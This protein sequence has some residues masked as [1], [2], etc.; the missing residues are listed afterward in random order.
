MRFKKLRGAYRKYL[1]FIFAS[2]EQVRALTD[3]FER[4]FDKMDATAA[5]ATAGDDAGDAGDDP[6]A[7][8]D[9]PRAGAY[10]ARDE[11]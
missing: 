8:A 6:S 9:D 5:D 3:T 11:A 2:I 10:D 4:W 7:D 1:V